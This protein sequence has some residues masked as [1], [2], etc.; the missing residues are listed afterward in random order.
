M[1][2]ENE[3]A[4][5][6]ILGGWQ[7]KL[8]QLDRR[9]SLLYFRG[10][11]NSIIITDTNPDELFNDLTRASKGR[12]FPYVEKRALSQNELDENSDSSRDVIIPGDLKT[13]QD[14]KQL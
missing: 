9:N 4:I 12:A 1:Q 8:L 6:D 13:D 10:K 7:T 5:D 14:P 11:S 2:E 3:K